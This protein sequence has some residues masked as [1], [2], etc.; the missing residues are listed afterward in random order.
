M[1]IEIPLKTIKIK[2][3]HHPRKIAKAERP[4]QTT[5][6]PR[7]HKALCFLTIYSSACQVIDDGIFAIS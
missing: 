3:V 5:N 2:K 4:L 1:R 6:S 7:Y